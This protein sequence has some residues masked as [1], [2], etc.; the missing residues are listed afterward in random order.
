M[1]RRRDR[2]SILVHC[3]VVTLP[4]IRSAAGP[5]GSPPSST[6]EAVSIL[7]VASLVRRRM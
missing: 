5:P 1:T 2:P 7:G 6:A 4:C 3:T